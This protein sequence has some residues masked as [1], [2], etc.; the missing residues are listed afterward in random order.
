DRREARRRRA[1]HP[2]RLPG[3]AGAGRGGDPRARQGGALAPDPTRPVTTRRDSGAATAA[4][5]FG[6]VRGRRTL[7]ILNPTSGARRGEDVAAD[8]EEALLGH[9][10]V[11]AEVRVT[12]GPDDALDRATSAAEEGFDLVVAGGG[13]G[14][15]TA[16]AQGVFRSGADT[17]VAVLPLGTGNGLARVLGI[18]LD[19]DGAL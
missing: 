10:A 11:A 8:L 4:A 12:G 18:P 13:D 7:A 2:L 17:P 3:P 16:V 6:R 1:R 15:V 9:G 5:P 14:T 19:P